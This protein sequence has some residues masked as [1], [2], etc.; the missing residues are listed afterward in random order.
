MINQSRLRSILLLGT[1]ACVA[2]ISTSAT[3]TAAQQRTLPYDLLQS[4]EQLEALRQ[5]WNEKLPYLPG[6]VL[7]KFRDGVE[8]AGRVRALSA[9][10]AGIEERNA[11]WIGDVLWVRA[12]GETDP[13]QLASVLGRQ[14]EVAWAQ[15][16]YLR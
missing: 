14:P 15:P 13:V 1:V 16:N 5:A 7:V 2:V 10:R 6:E 8:A 4:R 11:R 3:R 9:T 12:T